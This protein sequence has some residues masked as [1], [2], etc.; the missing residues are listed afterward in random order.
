MA[1]R[2]FHGL[3]NQ[4]HGA[5]GVRCCSCGDRINRCGRH[6]VD[7]RG[8]LD[9]EIVRHVAGTHHLVAGDLRNGPDE[10]ACGCIGHDGF[11]PAAA[12][13]CRLVAVAVP[14]HHLTLHDQ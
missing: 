6:H 10:I 5:V 9:A 1:A 3:V 7:A 11:P 2:L 4:R 13:P 14:V 8:R 12:R